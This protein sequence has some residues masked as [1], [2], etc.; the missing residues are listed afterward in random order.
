MTPDVMQVGA[1]AARV[2]FENDKIRVMEGNI[3]KGQK[4][5]MHSHPANLVYAVT[6]VKFKST[7]PSGKTEIVDLKKGETDFNEAMRHAVEFQMDGVYLQIEL[8]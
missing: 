7:L 8:K 1:K 2:V 4:Y 6:P 5:D 3:K